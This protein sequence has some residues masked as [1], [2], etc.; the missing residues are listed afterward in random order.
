MELCRFLRWKGRVPTSWLRFEEAVVINSDPWSCLRTCRVW[1]PDDC[2]VAPE[3]CQAA[4]ACFEVDE[5][6]AIR[7]GPTT[8]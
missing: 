6:S 7:H 4:R 1:G 3:L 8:A 2:P 5:L